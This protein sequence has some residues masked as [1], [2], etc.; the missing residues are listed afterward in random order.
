MN[1]H[2]LVLGKLQDYITGD[3]LLDTDD[4][5]CRQAI[6]RLLVNRKGFRRDEIQ[7]RVKLRVQ[8]GEKKAIVKI[9]YALRISERIGMLVKFGPGSIVTRRRPLLAASR[10]LTSC[11]IPIV[12]VTNSLDAEILDGNSG[13]VISRGVESIPDREQLL[14]I[15]AEARFNRIPAKVAEMESR[16]LYCYEVDGACPCDEDVCRL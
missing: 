15:V 4:E 12:V 3:T 10:I 13:K 8:A 5:R 2:H 7:P 11:Q 14:K 1:G 6:A 16:I 9:D